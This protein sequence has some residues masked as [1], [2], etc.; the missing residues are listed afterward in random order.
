MTDLTVLSEES[1]FRAYEEPEAI[2]RPVPVSAVTSEMNSATRHYEKPPTF[3]QRSNWKCKVQAV[4]WSDFRVN[5][6]TERPSNSN[7]T[8]N[9][10]TPAQG[11]GRLKASRKLKQMKEDVERLREQVR[12]VEAT[13]NEQMPRT[14]S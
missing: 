4:Y 10:T 9:R 8:R 6:R 14:R 11:A 1:L 5:F 12:S 13:L 2:I 3:M 7:G